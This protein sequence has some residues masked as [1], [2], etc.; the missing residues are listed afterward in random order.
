MNAILLINA[1]SARLQRACVKRRPV[2][3]WVWPPTVILTQPDRLWDRLSV[4]MHQ[5]ANM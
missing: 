4:Y 2:G 5:I 3:W 1:I